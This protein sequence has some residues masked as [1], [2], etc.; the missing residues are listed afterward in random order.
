[1]IGRVL[2]AAMLCLG[3]GACNMYTTPGTWPSAFDGSY[4][5][6]MT[7][8]HAASNSCANT[9]P[10]PGNLAVQNG[11]VTWTASPALTLYAPV[12]QDGSFTAQNGAVFFSGKITNRA[13]VA[14]INTGTCHVIY[15]LTK[16]T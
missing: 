1:M 5:G 10:A 16:S 9:A 2:S 3:V 4:T 12:A 14:R 15:D 7:S 11:S 8:L 13:M 6:T